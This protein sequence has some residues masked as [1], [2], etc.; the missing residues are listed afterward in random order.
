[1][2]ER[3]RRREPTDLQSRALRLLAGG[4][5]GGHL[6]LVVSVAV[7]AATRG[8]RSAVWALLAGLVTIVFFT[9]GQGI[10]VLVADADPKVLMVASLA[11]FALRAGALGLLLVWSQQNA[12]RIPSLDPIALA[13]TAIAV[14]VGWLTAEI[15][16]FTRLRIPIYDPPSDQRE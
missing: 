6:A 16:V 13:A 2:A 4:A 15:W 1:M 5:I 12:E 7:F 9:I 3:R 11:S 10:Q 8:P 14:V